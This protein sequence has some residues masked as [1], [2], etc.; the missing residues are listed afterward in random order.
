[1]SPSKKSGEGKPR[2]CSVEGC[3]RPVRSRGL[4]QTHYKQV[5]KFG[6]TKP[7][8]SK[9]PPRE[10]TVRFAGL[11]L[12]PETADTLSRE[13]KRRGIAPNALITDI[14]EDWAK[15]RKRK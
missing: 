5:R 12:T 2:V 8:K 9:R 15:K 11:S 4:C 13:S 1:M 3:G 7:I 6:K 10:H 14:L